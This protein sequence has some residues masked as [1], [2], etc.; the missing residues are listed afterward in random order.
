MVQW[1]DLHVHTTASDGTLT[2]EEL[3]LEI[4]EKEI[5]FFSITDHDSTAHVDDMKKIA[6]NHAVT[7]IPGVEVSVSY[8]A[9]EL[10]IL[11]YGVDPDAHALI[12]ILEQNQSIREAH[13]LKLIRYVSTK[14]SVITE[15]GYHAFAR[16][17]KHGGWKALNY[18]METGVIQSIQELFSIID[19]MNVPLRFMPHDDVI[20]KLKQL[21][22]TLVLA[23]PPQYFGGER[24]SDAFLNELVQLGLDGIECYSPYYKDEA[25]RSFYLACCES[26]DLMITSGSDYH[27]AFINTRHLGVPQTDISKIKFSFT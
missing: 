13:N 15:A 7:F 2:P 14:Y 25:D 19:E 11:T 17:P 9:Q 1:V 22:Y 5:T 23:H 16:N 24:L 26:R 6:A 12:E 10:H 4:L 27:G 21:G 18:L 20:P 8:G 3:M